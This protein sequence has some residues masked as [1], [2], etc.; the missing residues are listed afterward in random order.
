M[1]KLKLRIFI[2][3]GL[4]TFL[5]SCKSSTNNTAIDNKTEDSVN[6]SQIKNTVADS[7]ISDD[8]TSDIQAQIDSR[9]FEFVKN[10]KNGEKLNSFFVENWILI[11]HEDNRCDGST[12]GQ[13]DNLISTQID[14][15]IKLQVENDGDGWACDKK[16]PKTYDLD[17]DLI[18]KIAEWDRIEIQNYENQAM[19]IIYVLGAG[20]SDYLKLHYDDNNLIVKLEYRSEDPG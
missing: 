13:I 8:S 5:I 15:I 18:K 10:L 9:A 11:Y 16:E 20:E 12:D 4:M 19:N 6:K 14:S 7:K 1:I 17:F 2:F 3:L